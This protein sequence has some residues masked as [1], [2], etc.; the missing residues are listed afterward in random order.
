MSS[1][2]NPETRYE[3]AGISEV[4]IH[5]PATPPPQ[6]GAS[7]EGNDQ[8]QLQRDIIVEKD[9]IISISNDPGNSTGGI[10]K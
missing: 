4:M 1:D 5:G 6:S 10:Y 2:H 8:G 9:M 7:G 3:E